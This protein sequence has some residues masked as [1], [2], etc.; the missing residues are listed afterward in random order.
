VSTF[1]DRY[2]WNMFCLSAFQCKNI[3]SREA[4][5]AIHS[6]FSL[7][8][9]RI[10]TS[11]TWCASKTI[12]LISLGVML[13]NARKILVDRWISSIGAKRTMLPIIPGIR[14]DGVVAFIRVSGPNSHKR[15]IECWWSIIPHCRNLEEITKANRGEKN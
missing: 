10:S 9:R 5:R 3:P 7:G 8:Q 15:W 14:Q 4:S 11:P 1:C 2:P 12:L 13:V 6:A